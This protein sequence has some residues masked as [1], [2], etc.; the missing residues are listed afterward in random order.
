MEA[1]GRNRAPDGVAHM[2]EKFD[3][4][5]YGCPQRVMEAYGDVVDYDDRAA[6]GSRRRVRTLA[7]DRPA[8]SLVLV[9]EPAVPFR[10]GAGGDGRAQRR[11]AQIIFPPAD[12]GF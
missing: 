8:A 3:R 6:W 12:A 9:E 5:Q 11:A 2:T 4:E 10:P 1:A 7:G